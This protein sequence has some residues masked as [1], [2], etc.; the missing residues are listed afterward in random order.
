MKRYN[1]CP[2]YY[3]KVVFKFILLKCFNEPSTKVKCERQWNIICQCKT[4]FDISK[5]KS[6]S[7][8]ILESYFQLEVGKDSE[9]LLAS[10]HGLTLR[11]VLAT[12]INKASSKLLTAQKSFETSTLNASLEN[13]SY[14]SQFGLKI[15]EKH[16]RKY[17]S[18]VIKLW[19]AWLWH[20]LFW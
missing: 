15:L 14:T 8:G 11:L 17:Y 10:F 3:K 12:F 5:G 20:S 2:N 16:E 7:D 18:L 19:I 6:P 13:Y 1:I 9:T 4:S